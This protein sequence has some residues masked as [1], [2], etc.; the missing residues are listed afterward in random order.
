MCYSLRFGCIVTVLVSSILGSIY[1]SAAQVMCSNVYRPAEVIQIDF[2]QIKN[3]RNIENAEP[4]AHGNAIQI[5]GEVINISK[6]RK[7]LMDSDS[8]QSASETIMEMITYLKNISYKITQ[9]ENW[10]DQ[11]DV[12]DITFVL[13]Y[14]DTYLKQSENPVKGEELR[15]AITILNV[16]FD[17]SNFWAMVNQRG[18]ST[19]PGPN[20][21][22]PRRLTNQ[23]KLGLSKID[24]ALMAVA[25]DM[26]QYLSTKDMF[27]RVT[28][29]LV[30]FG[31]R[32]RALESLNVLYSASVEVLSD[33]RSQHDIK[34]TNLE[35]T[36]DLLK[37]LRMVLNNVEVQKLIS[38]S[39]KSLSID[40][41]R[42]ARETDDLQG[43]LMAILHSYELLTNKNRSRDT[44]DVRPNTLAI[45]SIPSFIDATYRGHAITA[46]SRKIADL[47][48]EFK[49]PNSNL[50]IPPNV[51]GDLRQAILRVKENY[52]LSSP[53][54]MSKYLGKYLGMPRDMRLLNDRCEELLNLVDSN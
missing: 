2:N 29:R 45:D 33:L 32:G 54:N 21:N 42:L 40:R 15:E 24:V 1:A 47:I 27:D 23:N 52:I 50:E 31:I 18:F 44:T 34:S 3:S 38:S 12:W 46:M 41:S 10:I 4:T 28:G 19:A 9:H 26:N 30:S 7:K 48:N 16:T 53:L 39:K 36:H 13:H 11:Y 14:A 49:R 43:R 8:N 35:Q 6:F 17:Q 20:D 51:R 37:K 5:D 25:I 22:Y